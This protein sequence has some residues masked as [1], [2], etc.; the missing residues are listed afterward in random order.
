MR[1]SIGQEVVLPRS[2]TDVVAE[3]SAVGFVLRAVGA[4]VTLYEG[5]LQTEPLGTLAGL[6]IYGIGKGI[7]EFTQ[8]Q[9]D[10]HGRPLEEFFAI[11]PPEP[12]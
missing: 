8:R 4:G 11:D 6:T 2:A 7:K 12:N 5:L 1:N 9:I 3:N 10:R